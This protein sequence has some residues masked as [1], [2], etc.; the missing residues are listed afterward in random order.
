MAIYKSCIRDRIVADGV[1]DKYECL[2]ATDLN[3]HS[4]R[5]DNEEPPTFLV[6]F[7]DGGSTGSKRA[8]H[9]YEH[10]ELQ[11]LPKSRKK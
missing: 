8:R 3:W 11:N 5:V 2:S 1:I 4:H 10:T 9:D 7:D 6:K